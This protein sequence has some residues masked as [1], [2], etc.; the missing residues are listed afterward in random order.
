MQQQVSRALSGPDK[1][2]FKCGNAGLLPTTM[3]LGDSAGFMGAFVWIEATS[4]ACGG[5]DSRRTPEGAGGAAVDPAR[6]DVRASA[7]KV[8]GEPRGVHATSRFVSR[9]LALA[10]GCQGLQGTC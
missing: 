6:G 5:K 4:L 7:A 8:R 3:P 10:D 9:P 1:P 2:G